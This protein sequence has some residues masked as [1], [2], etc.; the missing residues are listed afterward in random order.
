MV[1]WARSLGGARKLAV[2]AVV[3]GLAA[4]DDDKL[5]VDADVNNDVDGTGAEGG[6][7]V[8]ETRDVVGAVFLE[9]KEKRSL[10]CVLLIFVFMV[11]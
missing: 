9:K 3:G 10:F 8:L 2:A 6:T 11:V 1:S 7:S 4:T 5:D